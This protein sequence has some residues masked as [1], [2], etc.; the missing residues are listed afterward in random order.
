MHT[1]C[2]YTVHIEG[3]KLM[4]NLTKE[5]AINYNGRLVTC[6]IQKVN[7]YDAML[8]VERSEVYICQDVMEGE[9]AYEKGGYQYSWMWDEDVSEVQLVNKRGNTTMGEPTDILEELKLVGLDEKVRLLRKYGLVDGDGQ[10]TD[11]GQ[12]AIWPLL[13]ALVS[14]KLVENIKKAEALRK[15]NKKAKKEEN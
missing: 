4:P 3:E 2:T 15:A 9:Q 5:E 13:F 1:L 7:V 6:K 10:P 11:K 12:K 8:R 14:D